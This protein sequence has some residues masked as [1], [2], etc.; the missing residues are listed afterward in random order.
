M[1][2]TA[3][4]RTSYRCSFFLLHSVVLYWS[5]RKLP[6]KPQPNVRTLLDKHFEFYWSGMLVRLATA[7]STA[8]A[9]QFQKHFC[10]SQAKSVCR[11]RVCRG[12]TEKHGVW[13]LM[14]VRLAV[15]LKRY[16]WQ[17]IY[18]LTTSHLTISVFF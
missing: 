15:S 16:S 14:F 11:T 3:T 8:S 10:L 4:F 18:C 12:Q 5:D 9:C 7:T 17:F 2:R 1:H 13:Q 6:F